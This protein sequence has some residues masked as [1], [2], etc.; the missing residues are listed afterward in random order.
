[1]IILLRLLFLLFLLGTTFAIDD[2]AHTL[3][4]PQIDDH[5]QRP[6]DM[7]TVV[8]PQPAHESTLETVLPADVSSSTD[9]PE[10]QIIEESSQRGKK[11]LV[12]ST[13]YTYTV[14]REG[15]K[16][17]LWRCSVRSKGNHCGCTIGFKYATLTYTINGAHNHPPP[18]GGAAQL[19]AHR[20]IKS[21]AVAEV[22]RP[23]S[24]IVDEVMADQVDP[25]RPGG[26]SN[27][28][29]LTRMANRNRE[30]LRPSDPK[31][32]DF[33]LDLNFVP[34]AF[35]RRDVVV[36]ERR[37]LVFATD[38]QLQLLSIAKRW[39][40]DATFKIIRPPFTQLFSIHAFI[41]HGESMKQV[42]LVYVMMSGKRK[43]DYIAVLQAIKDLMPSTRVSKVMIDF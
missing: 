21:K 23:A 36:D 3:S 10:Y 7:D 11:K 39:Y 42:P 5:I 14:K 32:L 17:I 6:Q 26:L 16:S 25:A 1:M 40:M 38:R 27:P 2:P 13:G 15:D 35:F 29:N 31:D 41:R 4:R 12:D 20:D 24:A 37:H 33:Q 18:P 19:R 28:S 8:L 34:D 22:F 9:P 43:V 30:K